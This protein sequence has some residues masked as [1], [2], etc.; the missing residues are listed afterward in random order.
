MPTSILRAIL[1]SAGIAL[2]TALSGYPQAAA[3]GVEDLGLADLVAT[4][5]PSVVNITTTRYKEIKIPSG[6]A[7][8]VQAAEPDQ[9]LW[10]GSG[11]IVS[12]DGYVV[13]NKHVVHNGIKLMVTLND[14]AQFPADLIGEAVCC[15]IAVVRIQANRPFVPV[16]LGDSHGLRQGDF[17]IAV[18]NPL[19]FNTTVT[20]GI[21]SALNRDFHYTQFDNF[22]QTDAAINEGNS[23]GPLSNAKGEVIGVNS[24]FYTTATGTGNIGIGLAIPINDA[25]FLMSHMRDVGILRMKPAWLGARVQ[26]LTSDL[27]DAYHL[28]GPWGS[29]ILEVPDGTPAAEAG[30]RIGDIITSFGNDFVSDSRALLRHIL[31]TVPGTTVTFGILRDNTRQMMPVTLTEVPEAGWW[32]TF[33]GEPGAPKPKLSAEATTNFGLQLAAITPQLRAT[34]HLEGPQQGVVI[35]GVAIGSAAANAKINAGTVILRVRNSVVT[36]PDD[37]LKA[38]DDERK[39]MN[40]SVPILL[41]E[42]PGRRWV[43]LQFDRPS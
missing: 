29:I 7:A 12:T 20:T 40:P 11:F 41:V 4:L 31:E 26:S 43:S 39:Q 28:P 9:S 3:A 38:V 8:I 35:T 21:I 36:S 23:G 37:V 22:I 42:R 24:A 33:L 14:G 27:A 16:R 17:V 30:L 10:Y 13:T 6:N 34:Y 5:L 1:L 2:V 15:D 32:G 19:D 18:G 25:K